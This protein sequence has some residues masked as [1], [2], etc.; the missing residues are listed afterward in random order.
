VEV[1]LE[2][3]DVYS[4]TNQAEKEFAL[5]KEPAEGACGQGRRRSAGHIGKRVQQAGWRPGNEHGKRSPDYAH[6]LDRY[7][8]RLVAMQ[9]LPDALEVLRG[10]LDRI[11]RRT[12][13]SMTS[14][15]IFWNRTA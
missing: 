6:V 13:A 9:R 3:G 12:P 4:R 7:L 11:I 8:S 15:R 10:E 5:Y 2:V 14:W 1:A